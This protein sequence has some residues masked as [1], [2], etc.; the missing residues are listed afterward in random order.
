M[1]DLDLCVKREA[2]AR[3][4]M[5]VLLTLAML[6]AAGGWLLLPWH[7]ALS[8]ACLLGA[9]GLYSKGLHSAAKVRT[10][11]TQVA[12]G[13]PLRITDCHDCDAGHIGVPGR[14]LLLS[15]SFDGGT[16]VMPVCVD[17]PDYFQLF[18][19]AGKDDIK[20]LPE[21][22]ARYLGISQRR[23]KREDL[24]SDYLQLSIGQPE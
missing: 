16:C 10:Y 19:L 3:R 23:A 9:I 4:A 15:L 20:R 6:A 8:G 1:T 18:S 13:S 7:Q 12:A 22:T 14:V 21:L 5:A 24:Y 11:A 2:S 17:H